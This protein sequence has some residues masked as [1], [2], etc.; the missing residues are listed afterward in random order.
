M[1]K[2]N[3]NK[4][5]NEIEVIGPSGQEFRVST[6]KLM[7]LYYVETSRVYTNDTR[8]DYKS[9]WY[10]SKDSMF[11]VRDKAIAYLRDTGIWQR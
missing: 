2:Y 3:P 8:G 5:T 11:K 10:E 1:T 6:F 9:T 7:G 4:V